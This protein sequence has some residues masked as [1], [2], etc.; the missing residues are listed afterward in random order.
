MPTAYTGA[1]N[2]YTDT[3]AAVRC[4]EDLIHNVSPEEVPLTKMIGLNS[5]RD[6][7][8]FNTT[9][10]W[11]NDTLAPTSTTLNGAISTTNTTTCAVTTDA[12]KFIRAG[13]VIQIDSELIWVSSISSDT[14]TITR[15]FAGTTGATHADAATVDIVGMAL[16]EGAD[17][18]SSFKMDVST[19]YNYT[20]PVGVW[21]PQPV[22]AA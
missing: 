4:I 16:V 13:H 12:G 1:I 10:E 21:V 6:P 3:T 2:S 14:L 11:L 7:A 22:M 17:A 15:A 8:V 9:Y 5:I 20:R 19:N 18:P